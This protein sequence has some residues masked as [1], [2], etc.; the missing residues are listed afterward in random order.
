M[1]GG[2]LTVEIPAH[3][4]QAFMP[5]TK[6][7]SPAPCP[8]RSGFHGFVGTRRESPSLNEQLTSRETICVPPS[9]LRKLTN[10]QAASE[11]FSWL[12]QAPSS[13]SPAPGETSPFL[14]ACSTG[15]PAPSRPLPAPSRAERAQVSLADITSAP[16]VQCKP[17]LV[18]AEAMGQ[19]PSLGRRGCA[20]AQRLP[21]GE[22]QEWGFAP[23]PVT[24]RDGAIGRK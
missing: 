19:A 14:A 3:K 5:E 7:R 11:A 13:S 23:S 2:S 24:A 21:E 8:L 12:D 16:R 1:P 18:H 17:K 9:P 10:Q 4:A 20:S 15:H 6:S 22:L